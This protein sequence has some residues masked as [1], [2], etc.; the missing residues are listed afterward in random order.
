MSSAGVELVPRGSSEAVRGSTSS[1]ADS[2]VDATSSECADPGLIVQG[3]FGCSQHFA[4]KEYEK[5]FTV[6]MNKPN[7]ATLKCSFM[8]MLLFLIVYRFNSGGFDNP[9]DPKLT[10]GARIRAFSSI[11]PFVLVFNML[12]ASMQMFQRHRDVIVVLQGALVA[13]AVP[14][15]DQFRARMW[16]NGDPR[17]KRNLSGQ[18]FCYEYDANI[19]LTID[20]MIT[21]VHIVIHCRSARSW[22][23]PLISLLSYIAFSCHSGLCPEG[24]YKS[25]LFS[26]LLAVLGALTWCGRYRDELQERKAYR[27][28]EREWAEH[29]DRVMSEKDCMVTMLWQQSDAP[30]KCV[31]TPDAHF[32]WFFGPGLATTDTIDLASTRF[33]ATLL[34]SRKLID[35]K[36]HAMRQISMR[37]QQW[38][39]PL[40]F[41]RKIDHIDLRIPR[42]NDPVPCCLSSFYDR[43][44]CE[45]LFSVKIGAS[46]PVADGSAPLLGPASSSHGGPSRLGR[47]RTVCPCHCTHAADTPGLVL[48]PLS[49]G[50]R[51]EDPQVE[52][53]YVRSLNRKN[54]DVVQPAAIAFTVVAM[55]S[56]CHDLAT[57]SLDGLSAAQVTFFVISISFMLLPLVLFGL[58]RQNR[59]D[60]DTIFIGIGILMGI[61]AF[62][63][64]RWRIGLLVAQDVTA[65]LRESDLD[66]A[67]VCPESDT[68]AYMWV[69]MVVTCLHLMECRTSRSWICPVCLLLTSVAL[70][71]KYPGMSDN[72]SQKMVWGC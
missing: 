6:H 48:S 20:L 49:G 26:L 64:S 72:F 23:C 22:I 40:R 11:V 2:Q 16:I 46:D 50:P 67:M 41:I 19:L 70:C 29:G 4:E 33:A 24:T 38:A 8:L 39:S 15:I 12:A 61:L 30:D 14:A 34:D 58:S 62:V 51:F 47:P 60:Q 18:I 52:R 37:K 63:K 54:A 65:L 28:Y 27:D 9:F 1:V 35:L 13:G 32:A 53:E 44:K 21:Y 36:Q 42:E 3:C 43:D 10:S 45:V 55:I 56:G 31:V 17:P 66:V 25:I 7:A 57:T 68:E 69:D 5:G 71:K 59:F